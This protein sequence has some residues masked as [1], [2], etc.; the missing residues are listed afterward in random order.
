MALQQRRDYFT[1]RGGLRRI[2][3][4]IISHLN[5]N[6]L[7]AGLERQ[8]AHQGTM[9]FDI[10]GN[11]A[12]HSVIT[13]SNP[14]HPSSFVVLINIWGRVEMTADIQIL[15]Y[16]LYRLAERHAVAA[17]PDEKE[18]VKKE[19]LEH[20]TELSQVEELGDDALKILEGVLGSSVDEMNAI[21]SLLR[22]QT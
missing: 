8:N 2:R 11:R 9:S 21:R 4:Y 22:T 13:G 12:K 15:V 5:P 18:L 14:E 7:A 3:K 10:D 19:W 1:A 6:Y 17:T 20:Y 16:H